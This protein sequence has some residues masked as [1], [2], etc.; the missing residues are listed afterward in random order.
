MHKL[1]RAGRGRTSMSVV[2]EETNGRVLT[3]T[4]NR[5]TKM[6]ALS[7]QVFVE[8]AEKVGTEACRARGSEQHNLLLHLPAQK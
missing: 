2:L 7:K 3:L 5:P 4:I 1:L 6:N 8:L